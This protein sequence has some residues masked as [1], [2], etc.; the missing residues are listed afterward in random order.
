M[1]TL[2]PDLPPYVAGFHATGLVTKLD[3]EIVVIPKVDFVYKT[4]GKINFLL[5]I[6]T[7]IS[8]YTAGAWIDDALVGLKHFTHWHK[9]A[10]ISHQG[11]IKKITNFLGPLIPGETKGF[12]TDELLNAIQWIAIEQ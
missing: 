11:T 3:Y 4:Y 5:W 6:D 2:I 12:K 10:I 8:H 9:I 7:D 1:I